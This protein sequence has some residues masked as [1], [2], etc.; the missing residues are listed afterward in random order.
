[1]NILGG[2]S[3]TRIFQSCI[4]MYTKVYEKNEKLKG[5]KIFGEG[6]TAKKIIDILQKK[7]K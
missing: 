1:M 4:E 7:I 2:T 6:T 3:S 5:Q